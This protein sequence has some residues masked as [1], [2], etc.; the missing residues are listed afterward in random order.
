MNE[1]LVVSKVNGYLHTAT[2]ELCGWLNKMLPR[3]TDDWWDECVI[4]N[5]S[6]AQR[7]IA[8]EKNFTKLE[9]LDLAALLRVTYKSWY[10]MRNFA[11]LPTSERECVSNMIG[12]RNNWAHCRVEI[13]DKDI[14]ALMGHS[15]KAQTTYYQTAS[16]NELRA[17]VEA[18]PVL[19]GC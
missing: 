1:R 8:A 4:N 11:F 16:I 3:V 17:I 10:D 14:I 7:E 12:V 9:H 2:R 13:P 18:F 19:S 6:Y 5:L 15:D